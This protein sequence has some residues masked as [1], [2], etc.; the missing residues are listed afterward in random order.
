MTI[1]EAVR[2]DPAGRRDRPAA[3]RSSS[4]TWASRSSII[5]LA[6]EDDHARRTTSPT[7]TSRS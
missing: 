1:P 4:S 3:A 6:R 5:D 7:S 2:L